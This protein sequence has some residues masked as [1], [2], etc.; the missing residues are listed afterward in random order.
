MA[1]SG[2]NRGASKTDELKGRRIGRILTKMGKVTREQVHEGLQLQSQKRLPL[3]Q[4]L[5][6][7]KL[8]S[9]VQLLD[10]HLWDLYNRQIFSAEDMIDKA[11]NASTLAERIHEAGGTYIREEL[12]DVSAEPAAQSS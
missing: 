8:Q 11:K 7:L 3:G 6:E 4:L 5:I 2:A 12:A 1:R 10:D 9:L